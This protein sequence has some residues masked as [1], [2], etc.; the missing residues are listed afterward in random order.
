MHTNLPGWGAIGD[1]NLRQASR[2]RFGDFLAAFLA[3]FA[4]LC[5]LVPARPDGH[6][7]VYSDSADGRD[8]L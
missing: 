5:H 8:A 6:S 4:P 2:Q 3:T 1:S 7:R